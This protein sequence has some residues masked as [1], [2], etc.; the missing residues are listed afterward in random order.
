VVAVFTHA[1]DAHETGWFRSVP[2]L[3]GQHGISVYTP[4]SLKDPQ[5]EAL[6]RELQPDVLLSLYYRNMIPERIF[7]QAKKGAYNMH[8]SYLPRYRGRAPL[9][10]AIIHGEDHTGVSLHVMEKSADT[11][12][13]VDQEKVPIGPRETAGALTGR[14][15]DAA[16]RVLGRQL[17]A[18]LAGNPKKTP[19]NHALA[20]YFG[21]RTPEDGR[22][23]WAKPSQ[24]IFNLVRA[25]TRPFPGAFAQTMGGERLNVWWGECV[26]A[27]EGSLGLRPGTVV[28]AVPL[29]V[30]TGDGAFQVTEGQWTGVAPALQVGEWL[31]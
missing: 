17:A 10:W 1:D 12:D 4:E 31:E 22:I 7:G 28:N 9:N 27:P 19:Q 24:D 13:I 21:K 30:R 3:A 5:W 29:V 16:V 26:K 11:G 18:L 14:V 6:V 2:K 15:R 23:D 20:T 25:L 8:G